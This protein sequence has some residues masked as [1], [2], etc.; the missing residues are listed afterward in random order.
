MGNAMDTP[1][2]RPEDALALMAADAPAARPLPG[3]SPAEVETGEAPD[4]A[5][6][7]ARDRERSVVVRAW[8]RLRQEPSL[9]FTVAYV[10][11]SCIGLWANY[12]FYRRF[13]LPILEYM[14]ASDYLVAGL[15]D[16]A[17]ALVMLG[18]VAIVFVVSWP[19]SWRRNHP[20]RVARMQAHW[21]GRLVFP[22]SKWF[23]WRGVGLV[24]ETG[25]VLAALWGT[26]W[27]TVGY[28]Q[29]KAEHIQKG[30]GQPVQ[31][32]MAGEA[33]PRAGEARLLGTGGAFVFIW[34]LDEQR[35][36][37]IPVESIGRLRFERGPRDAE[38]AKAGPTAQPP[39]EAAKR[40]TGSQQR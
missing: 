36:E 24:P 27:A 21:W 19:D 20:E 7:L 40:S 29:Q 39:H 37:A 38:L 28:V 8:R 10:A 1:V 31:V 14:H 34:W 4:S 13:D 11:A 15:R 12:W 9:M 35:A 26:A 17:Y 5:E 22:R 2:D 3:D 23:R 32:T 25:I 16:P 30:S 33:A 18:A 6:T